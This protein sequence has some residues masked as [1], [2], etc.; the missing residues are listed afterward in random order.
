[1]RIRKDA[2]KTLESFE[3]DLQVELAGVIQSLHEEKSEKMRAAAAFQR[4]GSLSKT[5]FAEL[6]NILTC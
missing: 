3:D 4:Q 2:N 5:I 1:M 6:N